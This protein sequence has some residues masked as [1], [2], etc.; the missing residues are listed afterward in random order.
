M[1]VDRE[2]SET[3]SPSTRKVRRVH[4]RSLGIE[5]G[6]F[7]LRFNVHHVTDS[8]TTPV[9]TKIT[10]VARRERVA[11]YCGKLAI[12]DSSSQQRQWRHQTRQG[13]ISRHSPMLLQVKNGE[14]E[15][16]GEERESQ[17][18]NRETLSADNEAVR[19]GDIPVL[20]LDGTDSRERSQVSALVLE[21]SLSIGQSNLLY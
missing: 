13:S 6:S 18:G 5:L 16:H 19:R 4:D 10:I 3:V 20:S 2:R 17:A 21:L 14:P 9:A 15:I 1:L 12:P 11:R 8:N 7:Q